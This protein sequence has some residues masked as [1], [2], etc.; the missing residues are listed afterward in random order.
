MVF[1][2]RQRIN[3]FWTSKYPN[4]NDTVTLIH[5]SLENKQDKLCGPNFHTLKKKKGKCQR[6]Y[7]GNSRIIWYLRDNACEMIRTKPYKVYIQALP[8][9]PCNSN[10]STIKVSLYTY[11][12]EHTFLQQTKK[13]PIC[14]TAYVTRSELNINSTIRVIE[15]QPLIY[16]YRYTIREF[17]RYFKIKTLVTRSAC[18][19]LVLYK[20]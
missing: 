9:S 15:C 20:C 14:G 5:N 13:K 19:E 10:A 16:I 2:V 3:A 1:G 17:V 11:A 8:M 18:F 4:S 7:A 6:I 12:T